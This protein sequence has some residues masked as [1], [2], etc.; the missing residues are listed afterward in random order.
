[1]DPCLFITLAVTFFTSTHAYLS[2]Y[3]LEIRLITSTQ[4]TTAAI[5]S[6]SD[7]GNPMRTFRFMITPYSNFLEGPVRV[8]LTYQVLQTCAYIRSTK[9]PG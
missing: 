4:P 6:I 2:R 8:E 1:M 5:T 3:R 7:H 9:D